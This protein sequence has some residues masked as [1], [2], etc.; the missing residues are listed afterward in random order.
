MKEIEKKAEIA[1][2]QSNSVVSEKDSIDEKQVAEEQV[3]A[4][5]K[6]GEEKKIEEEQRAAEEKRMEEEQRVAEE[7]REAERKPSL[8]TV[9]KEEQRKTMTEE[10]KKRRAAEANRRMALACEQYKR[11]SQGSQTMNNE[12][13]SSIVAKRSDIEE[14]K[15]KEKRVTEKIEAERREA[16]RREA[17]RREAERKE[18]EKRK[19]VRQKQAMDDRTQRISTAI[20]DGEEEEPTLIPSGRGITSVL[21]A[22]YAP[23]HDTPTTRNKST[24]RSSI[25]EYP[26]YADYRKMDEEKQEEETIKED[27]E[28]EEYEE[29]Q[30]HITSLPNNQLPLY[31]YEVLIVRLICKNDR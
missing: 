4:E 17:E 2:S 18:T 25:F 9:V 14:G 8:Q 24:A 16:E 5:K 29:I 27:A 13:I 6:G 30:R 10:E 22:S 21:R 1:P 26:Q 3:E 15:M 12:D 11:K 28:G 19:T 20:S 31:P 7:K 23:I